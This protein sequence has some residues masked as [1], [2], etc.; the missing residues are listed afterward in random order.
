MKYL[1][2][3]TGFV[4]ALLFFLSMYAFLFSWGLFKPVA[5]AFLLITFFF[6]ILII[7]TKKKEEKDW[8]QRR[9]RV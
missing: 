6:F 2:L 7:I 8:Q 9:R 5:Y 3:I 4:G 1:V